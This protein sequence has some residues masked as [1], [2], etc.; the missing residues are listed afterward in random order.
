MP[1]GKRQNATLLDELD[2]CSIR[3]GAPNRFGPDLA[4]RCTT[5]RERASVSIGSSFRIFRDRVGTAEICENKI[6]NHDRIDAEC[7][8]APNIFVLQ[9]I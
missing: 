2:D 4:G 7:L 6:G 1:I 3:P 9:S 5:V 8:W